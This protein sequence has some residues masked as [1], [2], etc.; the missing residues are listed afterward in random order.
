M[1]TLEDVVAYLKKAIR[2]GLVTDGPPDHDFE[3]GYEAAL[4][5]VL[6]EITGREE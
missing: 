1:N 6:R 5:E 4:K 3:R 2:R